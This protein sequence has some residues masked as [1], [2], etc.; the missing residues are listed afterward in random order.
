MGPRFEDKQSRSVGWMGG[1]MH[2]R[3][4]GGI[5]YI[6]NGETHL[7]SYVIAAKRPTELS[8]REF[9]ATYIA[10]GKTKVESEGQM[11]VNHT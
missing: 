2:G 3:E 6:M 4:K 9:V 7:A 1:Y 10:H 5:K 8:E 11:V